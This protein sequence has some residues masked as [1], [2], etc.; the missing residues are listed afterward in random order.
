MPNG[1]PGDSPWSDFFTHGREL[2]PPDIAE[3]LRA[4]HQVDPELIQ[5]L[6]HPEMARWEQGRD[7]EKAREVLAAIMERNGIGT[8]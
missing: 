6:A 5:H 4:I 1:K 3:M 7:L 8:R 2:F